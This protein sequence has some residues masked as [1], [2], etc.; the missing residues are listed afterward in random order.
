MQTKSFCY[1]FYRQLLQGS[2]AKRS[3]SPLSPRI[4]GSYKLPT[5]Q[6]LHQQSSQHD[7]ITLAPGQI[8]VWW[9][10]PEQASDISLPGRYMLLLT[11][12]EQSY[13]REG[14]SDAVQKE[15]LL[16]RTLQRT[17]LARY[18]SEDFEPASLRFER[19]AHGKPQLSWEE[20]DAQ[21]DPPIHFSLTHTSSLLGIAVSCGSLVGLDVEESNRHTK[22][23]P[24]SLAR[25]RLAPLELASLEAIHSTEGRARRFVQLWTLKEAYVKAVGQ[26]ISA[27]PGLKGFS[28]LLH[29][30]DDIARRNQ[31]VS[32][33]KV[34]DTAYRINFQS[35]SH[36]NGDEWGFLLLSV[37]EMHTAALCVHNPEQ[38]QLLTRQFSNDSNASATTTFADSVNDYMEIMANRQINAGP[39]VHVTFRSTIPL[40]K[41]DVHRSCDIQ[42]VSRLWAVGSGCGK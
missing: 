34:A 13:V 21:P 11:P 2:R 36:V 22:A 12:E 38:T 3:L 29:K 1:C 40:V 9:L 16:A 33:A 23:D 4:T 24:L 31:Q 30:D 8:D 5:Y 20:A 35:D 41:D 15:R 32:A 26:G 28:V 19:N 14:S 10:H 25:R 27:P 39:Q 42:G 18:C 37:S 7:A 17:V 6:R